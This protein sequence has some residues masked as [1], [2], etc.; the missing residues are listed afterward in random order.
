MPCQIRTLLLL[1]RNL[2]ICSSA[3]SLSLSDQFDSKVISPI[4][5]LLQIDMFQTAPYYPQ[6]DGL[7]KWF[8]CMLTD[9]LATTV[10]EHSLSEKDTCRRYPCNTSVHTSTRWTPFSCWTGDE[11]VQLPFNLVFKTDASSPMMTPEYTVDVVEAH[12]TEYIEPERY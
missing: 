4:C 1:L 3:I 8:N 6:S 2:W 5:Q 12:A 10:N 9:M 11:Y 7:V